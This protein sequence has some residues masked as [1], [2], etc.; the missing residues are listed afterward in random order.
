M[1]TDRRRIAQPGND[2]EH[3]IDKHERPK[4][5][6]PKGTRAE[7]D[8]FMIGSRNNFLVLYYI[9]DNNICQDVHKRTPLCRNR[10]D[11]GVRF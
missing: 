3:Q 10:L 9:Y 6:A 2:G 4:N 1:I 5:L 11:A 7:I 8:F